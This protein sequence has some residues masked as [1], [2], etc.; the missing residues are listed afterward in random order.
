[1]RPALIAFATMAVAGCG[2]DNTSSHVASRGSEPDA[3]TKALEAGAALLQDRP[4]IDA[5][6][7]YL[8]GFHF[9]NGNMDG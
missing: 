6:N 7:S 8:D 1:M 5:I 9:Y 3:M 4:P 2:G